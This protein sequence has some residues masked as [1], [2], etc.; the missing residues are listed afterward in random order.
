M[1]VDSYD[2]ENL[3]RAQY[4]ALLAFAP[5]IA[6]ALAAGVPP[7]AIRTHVLALLERQEVKDAVSRLGK[8]SC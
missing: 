7:M 5:P 8:G 1:A 2:P 3:T 4:A 6:V